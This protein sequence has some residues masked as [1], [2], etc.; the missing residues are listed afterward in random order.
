MLDEKKS[1][2]EI[3]LDEEERA[4]IES[5]IAEEEDIEHS[6]QPDEDDG[7]EQLAAIFAE[8]LILEATVSGRE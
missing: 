5:M 2:F 1:F 6:L 4:D 7:L 8:Q 3:E